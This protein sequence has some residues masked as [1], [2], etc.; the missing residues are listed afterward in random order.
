M[1]LSEFMFEIFGS[2]Y[3]IIDFALT[4]FLYIFLFVLFYLSLKK[5]FLN[6]EIRKWKIAILS[7]FTFPGSWLVII[8]LN[9]SIILGVGNYRK[10]S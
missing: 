3:K 4:I 7:V 9:C 1:T 5:C 6:K 10:V 2:V 8:I